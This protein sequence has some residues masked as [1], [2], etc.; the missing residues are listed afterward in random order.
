MKYDFYFKRKDT[1]EVNLYRDELDYDEPPVYQYT[2]G[3]SCCD[4]NR[5]LYFSNWHKDFPEFDCNT[6]DEDQVFMI[7]KVVNSEGKD[8]T[9]LFL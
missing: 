9:D 5:A 4:C 1:G 8:V 3:N 7:D 2:E 6:S